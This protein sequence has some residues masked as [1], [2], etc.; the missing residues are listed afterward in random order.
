M[1]GIVG[2]IP[3]S[4]N[5]LLE[6]IPID[7]LVP[8]LAGD[9]VRDRSTIVNEELQSNYQLMVGGGNTFASRRI[10]TLESQK[11]GAVAPRGA[12]DRK[13]TLTSPQPFSLARQHEALIVRKSDQREREGL[14]LRLSV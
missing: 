12:L 5:R 14:A 13:H 8:S 7:P 2:L 10:T 3:I 4:A 9:T 6:A 1:A 11:S